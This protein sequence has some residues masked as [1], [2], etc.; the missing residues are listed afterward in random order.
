MDGSFKAGGNGGDQQI[1]LQTDVFLEA[2]FKHLRAGA[3]F[4]DARPAAR[5][6]GRALNYRHIGL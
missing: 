4:L 3:E 2:R 5:T 1:P 6:D